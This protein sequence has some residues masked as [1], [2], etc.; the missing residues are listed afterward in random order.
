MFGYRV[1]SYFFLARLVHRLNSHSSRSFSVFVGIY[2]ISAFS[3]QRKRLH[4]YTSLD[5]Y[6]FN[7]HWSLIFHCSPV[8]LAVN[9]SKRLLTPAIKLERSSL[10]ETRLKWEL[11]GSMVCGDCVR[12]FGS[13]S[14]FGIKS[15][16]NHAFSEWQRNKS[17][18]IDCC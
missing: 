16:F 2:G 4:Y 14:V 17:H 13:A 5:F 1:S 18:F 7:R 12:V 6:S 11:N 10:A 9:F 15:H 8:I 3:I